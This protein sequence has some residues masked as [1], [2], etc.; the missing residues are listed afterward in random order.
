M[1][2]S[3]QQLDSQKQAQ[4]YRVNE[5]QEGLQAC[6]ENHTDEFIEDLNAELA[7]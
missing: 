3:L 1:K 6:V 2:L 7:V 5:N 4:K